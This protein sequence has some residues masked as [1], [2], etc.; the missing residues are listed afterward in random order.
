MTSFKFVATLED[1]R[2]VEKELNEIELKLLAAG[3]LSFTELL[4]IIREKLE[5]ARG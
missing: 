2:T 1:G 4:E 5:E 3:I